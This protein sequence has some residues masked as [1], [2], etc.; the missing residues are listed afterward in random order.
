M[1]APKLNIFL[2]YQCSTLEFYAVCKSFN[3]ILDDLRTNKAALEKEV[4]SELL[5][6]VITEVPDLLD[7]CQ[8]FYSAIQ[9]KAAR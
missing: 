7:T 6:E 9:E 2:L 5:T 3:Q 8:R 4:K 1:T